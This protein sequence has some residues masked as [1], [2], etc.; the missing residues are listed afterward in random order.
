MRRDGNEPLDPIPTALAVATLA[1]FNAPY[2]PAIDLPNAS[3]SDFKR[4]PPG[5]IAAFR[6]NQTPI[7][8]AIDPTI[9]RII[10]SQSVPLT[11]GLLTLVIA[12][13]EGPG[14][15][16]GTGIELLQGTGFP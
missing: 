7:K 9:P 2:P 16:C 1:F 10:A 3:P 14:N 6:P 15:N 4:V 13:A 8:T 5:P 12:S 11:A